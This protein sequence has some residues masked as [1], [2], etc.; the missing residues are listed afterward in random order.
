LARAGY[1]LDLE[2]ALDRITPTEQHL[3]VDRGQVLPSRDE[4]VH[5]GRTVRQ[6]VPQDEAVDD[7]D[8][9]ALVQLSLRPS[10]F[11]QER[12]QPPVEAVALPEGDQLPFQL[13]T[14]HRRHTSA[15]YPLPMTP[16]PCS[17]KR[18]SHLAS[19]FEQGCAD[20]P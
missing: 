10:G 14:A 17:P 5:H 9:L 15:E 6:P 11:Q 18:D 2:D 19:G 20:P 1:F 13:G 3:P 4:P 16:K 8:R 7:P 12:R